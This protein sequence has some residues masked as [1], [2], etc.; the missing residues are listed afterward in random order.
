[1]PEDHRY[2]NVGNLRQDSLFNKGYKVLGW[3]GMAFPTLGTGDRTLFDDRGDRQ[4]DGWK[5]D[6]YRAPGIA[7]AWPGFS[8]RQ[9]SASFHT[10]Y[11]RVEDVRWLCPR[12][13]SNIRTGLLANEHAPAKVSPKTTAYHIFI[14]LEN[15]IHYVLYSNQ[16]IPPYQKKRF[17]DTVPGWCC[18]LMRTLNT[19]SEHW[20]NSVSLI[21]DGQR[22]SLYLICAGGGDVTWHL[23]ARSGLSHCQYADKFKQSWHYKLAPA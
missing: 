11:F 16:V 13:R 23:P 2:P 12:L 7:G 21:P 8:G 19:V 5:Q 9:D 22:Y 1:M 6:P 4:P 10:A 3:D 14:N 20:T 18:Y 15:I 17:R